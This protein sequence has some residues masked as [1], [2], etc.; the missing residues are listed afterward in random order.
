MT[1]ALSVCISDPMLVKQKCVWEAVVFYEFQLIFYTCKSLMPKI[2]KSIIKHH[3]LMDK[4]LVCHAKGPWFKSYQGN[5]RFPY[6]WRNFVIFSLFHNTIFYHKKTIPSQTHFGFTNMGLE[7]HTDRGTPIWNRK[8]LFAS[9]CTCMYF[10]ATLWK[11]QD[12]YVTQILREIKIQSLQ[13]CK[14]SRF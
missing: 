2:T 1:V 14:N 12:F 9:P 11:F 6:F 13:M 3:G 5:K 7:M 10:H 4:A 8:F